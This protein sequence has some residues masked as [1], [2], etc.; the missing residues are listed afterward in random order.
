MA[1]I[2]LQSSSGKWKY[3]TTTDDPLFATLLG[4]MQEAGLDL[5]STLIISGALGEALDRE[6]KYISVLYRW[7]EWEEKCVEI[8]T[9]AIQLPLP[10][11][12]TSM[13]LSRQYTKII[14]YPPPPTLWLHDIAILSTALDVPEGWEAYVAADERTSVKERIQHM[15][16]VYSFLYKHGSNARRGVQ[17]TH[18][19][20]AINLIRQVVDSAYDKVDVKVRGGRTEK[21]DISLL[22]P[23]ARNLW[24][25]RRG[26][27]EQLGKDAWRKIGMYTFLDKLDWQAIIP[28]LAPYV[29][30]EVD[31]V[32]RLA[33]LMTGEN[34]LPYGVDYDVRLA[35]TTKGL[36]FVI[37]SN[38]TGS[39]ALC[40]IYTR[41]LSSLPDDVSI[42]MIGLER[43]VDSQMTIWSF[44]SSIPTTPIHAIVAWVNAVTLQYLHWY[45]R[46][47]AQEN[48][49]AQPD[50]SV[51]YEMYI[52]SEDDFLDV[53]QFL[54]KTLGLYAMRRMLLSL[55][56]NIQKEELQGE[57]G[58]SSTL[59]RSRLNRAKEFSRLLEVYLANHEGEDEGVITMELG[60]VLTSTS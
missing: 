22:A 1:S 21:R 57:I 51:Q 45:T 29:G 53:V 47:M 44:S 9:G 49:D 24:L 15:R 56:H 60:R 36:G 55:L 54:G 43:I 39:D 8:A 23:F 14:G 40:R 26:E 10:K 32:L 2:E 48:T 30:M 27:G 59:A 13:S 52:I 7:M 38:I 4:S 5:P 11:L 50:Q 20:E 16:A 3:T 19:T 46:A 58:K 28:Y 12:K 35:R 41:I 34:I 25:I 31:R 17:D 37:G 33:R 6:W 18:D 42:G